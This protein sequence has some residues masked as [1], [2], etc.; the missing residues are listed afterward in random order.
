[1]QHNKRRNLAKLISN[2]PG[3]AAKAAQVIEMIVRAS[4]LDTKNL[5]GFVEVPERKIAHS[6]M[7]RVQILTGRAFW[8]WTRRKLSQILDLGIRLI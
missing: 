6:K 3:V 2:A 7:H 4:A 1:M 8:V 5:S